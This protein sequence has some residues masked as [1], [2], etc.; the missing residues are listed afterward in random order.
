MFYA[1]FEPPT[2]FVL[3][4]YLFS[5]ERIILEMISALRQVRDMMRRF[6]DIM[7]T[8]QLNKENLD[9]LLIAQGI[10]AR[11]LSEHLYVMRAPTYRTITGWL[12]GAGVA[13]RWREAIVIKFNANFGIFDSHG[14][15]YKIALVRHN[16]NR[17]TLGHVLIRE[18]IT[19]AAI[20]EWRSGGGIEPDKLMALANYLH[21]VPYT[22]L[23]SETCNLL[24]AILGV[25][26]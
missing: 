11:K 3:Q 23:A 26:P 8:L 14:A 24:G 19:P 7:L 22:L 5:G 16:M 20:S 10:S 18:T 4:H 25:T 15:L 13:P 1:V 6:G 17:E 12:D 2:C 21:V 9:R